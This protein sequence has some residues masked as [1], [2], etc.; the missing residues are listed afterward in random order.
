MAERRQKRSLGKGAG[1]GS[2]ANL[3]PTGT[4]WSVLKVKPR[5]LKEALDLKQT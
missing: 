5:S 1:G 2:T 4:R 3:N